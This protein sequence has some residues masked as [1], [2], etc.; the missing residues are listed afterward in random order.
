MVEIKKHN[1]SKNEKKDKQ[2]LK[3][4]I[5]II[6][7]HNEILNHVPPLAQRYCWK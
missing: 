6:L 3:C 2:C 4:V 5:S 7:H 1:Q